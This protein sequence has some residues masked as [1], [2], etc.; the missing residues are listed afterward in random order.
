MTKREIK[1]FLRVPDNVTIML[2]QGG[3]TMQY[4][5]IV[6]N[7]IGLKPFNKGMT[8][9][10]GMWSNQNLDELTKH[11]NPVVVCDNVTDNDC[12]KMVSQDKWVIDP[13]ASF[14]CMCSNETVNGFEQNL[15]TFP[16]HLIPKDMPVC[17]DMSSNIGT[18]IVPW[19]KVGV[20]YMG[21]QKN[22]GTA[23]CTVVIVRTDLIGKQVK[24]TPIL[25]DWDTFQK[26][27]D[28]YYNTP[29]VW[30]MYVTGLNCSYMNQNGGLDYYIQLAN[31]RGAMLWDAIKAS[32]GYYWSK[33][34]DDKYKSRI[35]VIFRIMD[36]NLE[37]E[38]TFIREAGNVGIV[39]I[40]GHTFNAGIRI[41]M[42]NAMPISGVAY[43][44]QFMREF[45]K[46][47]PDTRPGK[48]MAR[49]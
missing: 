31:Q 41:S 28:T 21:A 19:D 18:T 46:K 22:L 3:A 6:K 38:D 2:Q 4:T 37:L 10:T 20:V 8:M 14:F 23:G 43:L 1:K 30:P 42:Y 25:C 7:L 39:Q 34:T 27:P 15:E 45:Q 33:I 16:W 17:V 49:M 24:D 13:E 11:C 5:A 36:K 26:S 40:K 47:H 29:A 32:N 9:R 12:T 44:T 35:N 48:S